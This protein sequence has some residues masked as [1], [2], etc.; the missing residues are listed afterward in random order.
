MRTTSEPACSELYT[1]CID[2]CAFA[3]NEATASNPTAKTHERQ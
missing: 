1:Y 2:F 3:A